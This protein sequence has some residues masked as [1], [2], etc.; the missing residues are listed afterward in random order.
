MTFRTERELY[1][2]EGFIVDKTCYPWVAYKGPRFQ[3]TAI[4]YIMTDNESTLKLQLKQV[5]DALVV[6]DEHIDYC[7][8]GD[9]WER[10]CWQDS[11]HADQVAEAVKMFQALEL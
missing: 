9:A 3:P 7:G 10:E 8:G 2:S 4:H 6:A 11:G 5:G 1:E